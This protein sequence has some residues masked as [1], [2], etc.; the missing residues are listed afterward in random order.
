MG[1][2][3]NEKSVKMGAYQSH[4]YLLKNVKVHKCR[5]CTTSAKCCYLN[6]ETNHFVKVL[7]DIDRLDDLD[8]YNLHV[9]YV[10]VCP[11]FFKNKWC[12]NTKLM[13]D[14]GGGSKVNKNVLGKILYCRQVN[15]YITDSTKLKPDE[16]L[17]NLKMGQVSGEYLQAM[18]E[19][20]DR[21]GTLFNDITQE[22]LSRC[23]LFVKNNRNE[24]WNIKYS[25]GHIQLRSE[26]TEIQE[27]VDHVNK[28]VTR[29]R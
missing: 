20:K 15:L 18:Y 25:I 7:D 13:V 24:L 8:K 11:T 12:R 23:H 5:K 26:E 2:T 17:C 6:E 21:Y 29:N 16:V 9:Y 22:E 10:S 4:L 19:N 27:K 14:I 28:R 3:L 1:S